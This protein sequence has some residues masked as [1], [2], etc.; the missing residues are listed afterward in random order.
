[1]IRALAAAALLAMPLQAAAQAECAPGAVFLRGEW[2]QARFSVELADEPR[3]RSLGLMHRPS[4]PRSQGMLFVYPEPQVASF[5]MKNTLIE[6]DMIFLGADG[7]VRHVHS[8]AQP[9]DLSPV[10]GGDDILAVLEVN[11]GLAEALGIG[12]GTQMR[13][14]AFGADAAWPC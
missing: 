12:P 3:E 5:W 8:R 14:P 1:M 10:T 9:G 4:L 11:G 6:L 2:G 13:H 7:V